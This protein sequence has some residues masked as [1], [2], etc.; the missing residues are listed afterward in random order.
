MWVQERNNVEYFYYS[1]LEHI[2]TYMHTPIKPGQTTDEQL[3]KEHASI[4]NKHHSNSIV[5][6]VGGET[7]HAQETKKRSLSS[8]SFGVDRKETEP[9]R[10]LGYSQ[11]FAVSFRLSD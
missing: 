11:F 2:Y 8:E 7:Q 6:G 10:S 3:L 1:L 4:V 5:Q 9:G